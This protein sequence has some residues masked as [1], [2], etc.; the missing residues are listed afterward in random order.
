ME[1]KFSMQYFPT[2]WELRVLLASVR[3]AVCQD[4]MSFGGALAI[5][6]N[7]LVGFHLKVLTGQEKI[8]HYYFN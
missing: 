5:P 3:D 6:A 7:D 4:N 2:E 8:V 1:Y